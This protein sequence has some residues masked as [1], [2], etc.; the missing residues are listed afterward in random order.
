MNIES[1]GVGNKPTPLYLYKRDAVRKP[2]KHIK[3]IYEHKNIAFVEY[4]VYDIPKKD[5]LFKVF[6]VFDYTQM[7]IK[8]RRYVK[9]AVPY[10]NLRNVCNK[11]V[12]S[13]LYHRNVV[14]TLICMEVFYGKQKRRCYC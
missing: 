6:F 7:F 8:F 2:F 3:L 12:N 5:R 14:M 1:K 4:G 10:A 11:T 9:I 13:N